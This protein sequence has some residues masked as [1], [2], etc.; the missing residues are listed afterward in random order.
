MPAPAVWSIAYDEEWPPWEVGDTATVGFDPADHSRMAF[1][2]SDMAPTIRWR[3][4]AICPAC[5]APVEQAIEGM[6]EQPIC[7][8]CHQPLPSDPLS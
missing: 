8:F 1:L 2:G 4:P 6:A 3:V 7:H 5:G